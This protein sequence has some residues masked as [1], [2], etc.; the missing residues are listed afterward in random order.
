MELVSIV[1]PAFNVEAT[2]AETLRSLFSQTYQNFEIIVVDDGS[3][4]DTVRITKTFASDRRLRIVQ[5][6]NRGL[7]GARNTGISASNGAFVGFCD[8]D[9]LWEPEKLEVHVRHLNNHPHVGVSYAGSL[10]IHNDGRSM[11]QAQRPK[12]QNVD[13]SDILKRNPIGNGSAPV[14]RKEVLT[15]IAYR[16]KHETIRDWYF[17]ET[18]RQS[19]DIECWMRIALTTNWVFEGVPG[20]LTRYRITRGGLSAGTDNQL[21][22][23]ERMIAK[24]TPLAPA[25]FDEYAPL[26]RAYQFRYLC[27]RA[28]S[29]LDCEKAMDWAGKWLGA[30]KRTFIE[31]PR[32]SLETYVAMWLMRAIGQ[33][34]LRGLAATKLGNV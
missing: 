26:A 22:A 17:D 23:W 7:A 28:I 8:A 19:E 20:L 30:S 1:V 2:L 13:A 31:E 11:K 16:P 21:L 3:S 12:L 10:L 15:D 6:P 32:K 18:F 27:R 14:I 24:L 4:D 5:Q 33:N 34:T 29:D 9:D 25:L